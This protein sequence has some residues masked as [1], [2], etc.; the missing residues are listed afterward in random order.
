MP[1]AVACSDL[2]YRMRKERSVLI[3]E[4]NLTET[5]STNFP[6]RS[7]VKSSF[8]ILSITCVTGLGEAS[9]TLSQLQ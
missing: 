4:A 8:Y 7:E 1:P 5:R 3:A 9:A 6:P 2:S